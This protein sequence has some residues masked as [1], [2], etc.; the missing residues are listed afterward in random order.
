[1]GSNAAKMW[2]KDSKIIP[3]KPDGSFYAGYNYDENFNPTTDNLQLVEV[4]KFSALLPLL[5]RAGLLSS[6]NLRLLRYARW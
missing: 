4:Q 2:T 5:W 6:V 3:I 1:V